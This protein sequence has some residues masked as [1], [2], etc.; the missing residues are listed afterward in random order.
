MSESNGVES[1]DMCGDMPCDSGYYWIFFK[2]MKYPD[3]GYLY[4][5]DMDAGSRQVRFITGR[6]IRDGD[7]LL[8]ESK[9]IEVQ[10][11]SSPNTKD[12]G[13]DSH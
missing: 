6:E 3:L 7:P 13:G 2:G 1:I 5:D 8:R 9:W 12:C 4:A 11:P 10:K